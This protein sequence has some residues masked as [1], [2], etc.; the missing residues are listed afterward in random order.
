MSGAIDLDGRLAAI[1]RMLIYPIQFDPEPVNGIDR[2]LEHVVYAEHLK[3]SRTDVIAAID[4]GLESQER[5]S[6]LIPQ[7]HSEA[8]IRGF[9]AAL[10]TRMETDLASSEEKN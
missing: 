1:L 2:V 4:V 6:E 5:L 8:M 3:L 7:R 10:R 9:L